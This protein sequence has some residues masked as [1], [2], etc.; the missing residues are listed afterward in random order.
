MFRLN[1]VSTRLHVVTDQTSPSH[2]GLQGYLSQFISVHL[3]RRV[4]G[5]ENPAIRRLFKPTCYLRLLACVLYIN[6]G[7][8]KYAIASVRQRTKFFRPESR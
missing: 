2:L 7:L 5:R 4:E 8:Q 3:E 6:T 1:L